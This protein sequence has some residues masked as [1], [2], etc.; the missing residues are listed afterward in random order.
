MKRTGWLLILL[1]LGGIIHAYSILDAE[2]GN[3][4]DSYNGRSA[5]IGNTGVALG[6]RLFDSLLNPANL[7]NL[8]S[9]AGF[10]AGNNLYQ[11]NEKRSLPM[12]NS[13]DAYSGEATYVSNLNYFPYQAFGAFYNHQYNDF[14][15][16]IAAFYN[17]VVCFDAEYFEEVR[18]NQN[19]NNNSYPPVL[20]K[21]YIESEGA[22]SALSGNLSFQYKDLF[23]FGLMLSKLSGDS[24]WQRRIVWQDDAIQMMQAT[25]DTLFDAHN[26]VKRDYDAIQFK[27]G[28]NYKLSE[29]FHLGVSYLPKTEFDVTGNVDGVD[30]E[31]AVYMYYSKLD[32]TSTVVHTDSIM[33]SEYFQPS[34]MRTGFTYQPRNIMKTYFNVEI[35]HVGWSAINKLYDDQWNYYI[36]I[37]HQLRYSIPIRL[38]FSFC[39]SYGLH[40]DSGITFADKV[41][42]PAFT[43]GTG[44]ELLDRFIVDIGLKF[45]NRQY[46]ALDLFM[47]S[48][49]DY[50]ALW[51]NPQYIDLQDRGWENPDTVKETILELKTSVSF[52]W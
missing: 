34:R 20:A 11:V 29:R 31:N 46:E 38:G 28:A 10:Q 35:E 3:Q 42:T 26:L 15:F 40:E 4:V 50:D 18:N 47:D 52:N 33:Y 44:F 5:A 51:A 27:L 22:I 23:S 13:F 1:F 8:N 41:I 43:A 2:N 17:P 6:M 16:G 48:Y 19:S 25:Q 36:G 21:N 14:K 12:Y 7:T 30:V 39:T 49:Y 37:E 9:V 32:S 45:S 24:R